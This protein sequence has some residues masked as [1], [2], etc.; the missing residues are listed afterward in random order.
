MAVKDRSRFPGGW[1]YF[2]FGSD[3]DS[4]AAIAPERCARV[5]RGARGASTT[6]SSNSIP[7]FD[8]LTADIRAR[9]AERT[10][11]RY[12]MR[13]SRPIPLL[14]IVFRRSLRLPAHTETRV[15]H[16]SVRHHTDLPPT[17]P[18]SIPLA[19]LLIALTVCASTPRWAAA[20]GVTTSALNG[21]ITGDDGKPLADAMVLAVHLPSGTEY[22]GTARSRRSV[23]ACSTCASADRTGSPRR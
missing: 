8:A 15:C 13:Q 16:C 3:A 21:F 6:S 10:V 11:V 17:S 7:S 20:Q 14:A 9:L 1:A 4:A 2:D 12:P 5:P 18:A 22:R 19:L 23:S